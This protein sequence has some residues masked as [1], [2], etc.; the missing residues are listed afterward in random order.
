MQHHLIAEA[1]SSPA[2]D[3][4]LSDAQYIEA[5][6]RAFAEGRSS[7]F[8]QQAAARPERALTA[9]EQAAL[10]AV[11]LV[12]GADM[13]KQADL[14]R[15][16]SVQVF[17]RVLAD[18]LT[19]ATVA[20]MLGVNTSR[21]RQR[22]RDRSLL[23]ITDGGEL[24]FPASQ[25]V[26]GREVPGLRDVLQA[27]PADRKPIE[28]LAWFRTPTTELPV[29][30]DAPPVSPRDYLLGTGDVASVVSLART[31]DDGEAA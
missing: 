13:E 2:G 22:A 7:L 5:A 21:I 19:T 29:P 28:I 17:F 8:R 25:F 1:D 30:T 6:F 14:A 16:E 18:S 20:E 27:L 12:S 4:T 3:A 15:Q 31:L 10:A 23:A 24:R 11:G 26:A 9:H